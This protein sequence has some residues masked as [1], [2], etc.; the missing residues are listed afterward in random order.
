MTADAFDDDAPADIIV[1]SL[2]TH[3]LPDQAVMHLMRRMEARATTGWFVNDLHRHPLPH[4]AFALLSR[5]MRWHPFVRHDG[6]V[7]IRRAFTPADWAT[8]VGR[9]GLDASAITV[10]RRFPY[11]V[12]VTRVKA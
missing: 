2:F 9:A 11:R 12:C 7:S 8:L 6:P 4:A 5:L 10:A 1:S 3:H